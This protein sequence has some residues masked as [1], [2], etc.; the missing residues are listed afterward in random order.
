MC[1]P[2]VRKKFKLT[3]SKH[4][5]VQLYG[6]K[7][8]LSL[9]KYTKTALSPKTESTK[10]K[11]EGQV[12]KMLQLLSWVYTPVDVL[13]HIP[14]W[15][16]SPDRQYGPKV[17]AVCTNN[18]TLCDSVSYL[19]VLEPCCQERFRRAL[20][21]LPTIHKQILLQMCLDCL[22]VCVCVC[23]YAWMIYGWPR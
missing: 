8:L 18:V 1:K 11:Y 10:V 7:L 16:Y 4:I 6:C 2:K 21:D 13:V 15:V 5:L 12:Q 14:S 20:R 19:D 22:V 9:L 23:V 17:R 3:P